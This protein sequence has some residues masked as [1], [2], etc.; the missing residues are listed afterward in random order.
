VRTSSVQLFAGVL[1]A[2][3]AAGVRRPGPSFLIF[4]PIV[5][6]GSSSSSSSRYFVSFSLP[7]ELNVILKFSS[8]IESISQISYDDS[9]TLG[10]HTMAPEVE[11]E[12]CPSFGA[13]SLPIHLRPMPL[14]GLCVKRSDV[15]LVGHCVLGRDGREAH[16]AL[17]ALTGR[18]DEALLLDRVIWVDIL[19]G[20]V[21]TSASQ[22]VD[23]K[24]DSTQ[25]PVSL[26]FEGNV[27]R[28]LGNENLGFYN[29]AIVGLEKKLVRVQLLVALLGH[30]LSNAGVAL[31]ADAVNAHI[32][33]DCLG[34]FRQVSVCLQGFI[35]FL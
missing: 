35:D 6:I 24:F 25:A 28:N 30:A 8:R 32:V 23:A 26:L 11:A 33:S 1:G 34:L 15:F 20:V 29:T 31:T 10:I 22:D 3:D 21:I 7:L 2:V 9:H 27:R 4:S 14:S 16:L 18:R 12:N 17:R 13:R 5:S 19:E